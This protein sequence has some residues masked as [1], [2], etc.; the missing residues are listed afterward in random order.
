[1]GYQWLKNDA[2]L[3]GANAATLTLAGVQATD[4]GLY[5]L[6]VSNSV[7]TVTTSTARLTVALP[8]VFGT[9]VAP[10]GSL[11]E[12][13]SVDPHYRMVTSPDENAPGPEAI[14]INS[15][16]P[17]QA[18]VWLLNGPSSK[19]IGPSADQ[20]AGNAEGEYVYE[21]TFNLTGVDV[22]RVRLV[23]GWATDNNGLDIL[24]NGQSTGL[25]V[26]GF[27]AL[28]PFTISTGLVEGSN[29]LRFRM[30]NLPVT[31]NPTGLRVDLKAILDTATTA[32]TLQI[33][34]ASGQVTLS[35]SPTAAGQKLQ[36]ASEVNGPW[37]EVV[38]ASSPYTAPVSGDHRY[39]RVGP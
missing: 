23:G 15:V 28:T 36:S 8:G 26:A 37:A 25:T 19:W 34:E 39:Y 2:P 16:W 1:L 3:E 31:P 22:S 11:L 33:S 29:T 6:V 9:G 13:G 4:E 10:D 12:D 5:S 32:P 14:V 21:T 17:I 35:W 30:S 7:G 24:V 18:G 20:A 38:G 27:A